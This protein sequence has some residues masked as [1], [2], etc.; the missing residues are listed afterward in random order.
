M[1]F[2]ETIFF[3]Q[4]FQTEGII[5][6]KNAEGVTETSTE[7]GLTR[8]RKSNPF[9]LRHALGSLLQFQY[10]ICFNH[11]LSALEKLIHRSINDLMLVVKNNTT[12]DIIKDR[13]ASVD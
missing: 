5:L 1:A 9:P 13:T 6:L 11:Y 3:P 7:Y 2:L 10:S 8:D 12:L 4:I